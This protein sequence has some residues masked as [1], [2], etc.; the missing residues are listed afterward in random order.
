[1]IVSR[2]VCFIQIFT[3]CQLRYFN[4]FIIVVNGAIK[5][6]PLTEKDYKQARVSLINMVRVSHIHLNILKL[7]VRRFVYSVVSGKNEFI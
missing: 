2:V 1:M 3:I 4:L 5:S 6:S 7:T